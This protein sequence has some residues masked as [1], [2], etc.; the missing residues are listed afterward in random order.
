METEYAIS[1]WLLSLKP[2]LSLCQ[3]LLSSD[4]KS[5]SRHILAFCWI[6]G[7]RNGS[8]IGVLYIMFPAIYC[9]GNWQC[10]H[11][12]VRAVTRIDKDSNKIE[13]KEV[14]S[15]LMRFSCDGRRWRRDVFS[16]LRVV[17]GKARKCVP[18]SHR[19]A[20]LYNV[21]YDSSVIWWNAGFSL[22]IIIPYIM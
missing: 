7:A 11:F 16:G 5:T 14:I 10:K 8:L 6:A 17:R 9:T 15:V 4:L 18:G 19:Q 1:N 12:L 13:R 2:N 20:I 21:Y 3:E 22:W